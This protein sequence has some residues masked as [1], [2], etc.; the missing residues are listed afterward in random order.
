[1]FNHLL[2]I[3]KDNSPPGWISSQCE[4]TD[5]PSFLPSAHSAHRYSSKGCDYVS[6]GQNVKTRQI[7]FH[8][9]PLFM[10]MI[11]LFP[12]E[13]SVSIGDGKVAPLLY[14]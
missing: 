7:E 11:A 4:M 13:I 10:L 1:M 14:K 5:S 6:P 2:P 8:S 3:L 12:G 9:G